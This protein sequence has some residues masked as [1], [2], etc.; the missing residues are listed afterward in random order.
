MSEIISDI[1]I[2]AL[3]PLI[4]QSSTDIYEVSANGTGSFKESRQQMLSYFQININHWLPAGHGPITVN[5]NI[6][7]FTIFASNTDFHLTSSY[8]AGSVFGFLAHQG[9]FSIVQ[10]AGQ[11][12]YIGNQQTTTGVTGGVNSLDGGACLF[13]LSLD[14]VN[15]RSINEIGNF[16]LN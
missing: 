12:I 1:K 9:P 8:P 15:F 10:V 16:N 4:T 7:S 2:T 6:F 14:G 3:D 5:P 11:T 13:L